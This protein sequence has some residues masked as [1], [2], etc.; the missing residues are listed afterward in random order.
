M[1]P[2]W[3]DTTGQF[4]ELELNMAKMSYALITKSVTLLLIVRPA[5]AFSLTTE[6]FSYPHIDIWWFC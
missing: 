3:K 6:T 4:G 2:I 1:L 5:I